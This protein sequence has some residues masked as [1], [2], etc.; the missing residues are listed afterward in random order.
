M[1]SGLIE[2]SNFDAS[3]SMEEVAKSPYLPTLRSPL[4][5]HLSI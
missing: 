5:M 4:N 1:F 2:G 3:K